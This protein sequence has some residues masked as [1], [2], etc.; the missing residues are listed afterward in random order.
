MGDLRTC[1]SSTNVPAC[2]IE[3]F[4]A[5]VTSG[6][7]QTA[8]SFVDHV[9]E[10]VDEVQTAMQWLGGTRALASRWDEQTIW[11]TA[12]NTATSVAHT[13]EH[14][15]RAAVAS[16]RA[17]VTQFVGTQRDMSTEVAETTGRN[18]AFVFDTSTA[19]DIT[20]VIPAVQV[21]H[22]T[23]RH[24]V[25]VVHVAGIA[26]DT[27]E[28]RT[29]P[30]KSSPSCQTEVTT[31]ADSIVVKTEKAVLDP[32]DCE[33]D[34]GLMVPSGLAITAEV[35]KGTLHLTNLAGPL[36][37]KVGVGTLWGEIRSSTVE[38][39]T[40]LGELFLR[41]IQMPSS[42]EV[43]IRAG[44]TDS[45]LEF[46][47]GAV[48]APTIKSGLSDVHVDVATNP[49]APFKVRAVTGLADLRLRYHQ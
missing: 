36:A 5:D 48:V 32:G 47:E 39:R 8:A 33:V 30:R 17:S 25:G 35:R 11:A 14:N 6:V 41:W 18:A 3:R 44:A 49:A 1:S 16:F 27:I 34:V 29:Y 10:A 12:R 43:D 45:T 24:D 37:V 38:V 42:G 20:R 22:L 4:I 21:D 15:V 23:V 2:Y 7:Q 46:P 13:V 28:L 26:T 9:V 31:E 40:G 19:P